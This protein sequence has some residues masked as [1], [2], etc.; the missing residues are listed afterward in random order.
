MTTGVFRFALMSDDL[1]ISLNEFRALLRKAFEGIYGHSRDWNALA[2]LVLWLEYRG[3]DG[4]KMFFDAEPLLNRHSFKTD[5]TYS[6]M[7]TVIFG[8]GNSLF[9]LCLEAGDI[10]ISKARNQGVCVMQLNDFS[11]L[12]IITATVDRCVKN[13]LSAA[14]WWPDRNGQAAIAFQDQGEHEPSFYKIELPTGFESL[15]FGTIIAD[16]SL[17]NIRE[18]FPQWFSLLEKEKVTASEIN[19]K[20]LAHLD[21]GYRINFVDYSHLSKLAD[22]VL[23]E[24]TEQSRKG[25]GE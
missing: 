11:D 12:E 23:V 2:D 21:N 25:A 8:N 7:E 6:E 17:K 5:I 13:G 20:Y 3:L 9:S 19:N 18:R 1:T 14:A 4:L 16:K 10:L 24:A 15:S 22:R